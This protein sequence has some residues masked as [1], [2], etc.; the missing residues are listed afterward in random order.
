MKIGLV[1]SGGGARGI[2]HIG[3]IQA[4]QERG[5]AIDRISATSSGAF[6]GAMVAYGYTPEEILNKIVETKFYPYIRPG[7]GG[8]GLLQI[9][10]IEDILCKYIPE[11]TFECL[12]I[13]LVIN[14]TDIILGEEVLFK[15]GELALPLLASCCIPGLFSPIRL[16]DRDLVDGGV[17]NNL[18]VENISNEVDYIIG[19][20]CNPFNLDKPL[21]KT[22]EIIYRSLI[23][24]MHGKTRERFKKCNLLIEPPELSQ[25][26][27]FDFRKARQ[28]YEVGYNYTTNMLDHTLI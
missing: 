10:R 11:N 18:P 3:V 23:L 20:H 21:K 14:A 27:I 12:R 28:L 1:L 16:Q 25:F 15:N 9:R 17:L 13:P 5:V 7:F 4:L 26:S 24:A 19:S 6:V 22:T 2:A 8:N